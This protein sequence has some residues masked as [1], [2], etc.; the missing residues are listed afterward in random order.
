MPDDRDRIVDDD[1]LSRIVTQ[2]RTLHAN[3]L[4]RAKM[5]VDDPVLA[6]VGLGI[7]RRLELERLIVTHL[8]W[9]QRD[10][11]LAALTASRRLRSRRSTTRPESL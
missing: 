2:G 10:A 6:L 5:I 7:A 3:N 11:A 4:L 1:P 9:A 8:S